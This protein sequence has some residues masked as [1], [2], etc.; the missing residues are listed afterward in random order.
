MKPYWF[1]RWVFIFL[2][3]TAWIY[4]SLQ[5]SW[6]RCSWSR[7]SWW[8]WWCWLRRRRWWSRGRRKF[9]PKLLP[10][11][12]YLLFHVGSKA[13][14]RWYIIKVWLSLPAVAIRW[15]H[16]Q[17]C[18]QMIEWRDEENSQNSSRPIYLLNSM[19]HCSKISWRTPT[20]EIIFLPSLPP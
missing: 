5:Y 20:A 2:V 10:L 6:W 19:I 9:Q 7:S 16:F 12:F 3:A 18:S 8:W 11:Q 15:V 17:V 13:I 4:W 1:G 14:I